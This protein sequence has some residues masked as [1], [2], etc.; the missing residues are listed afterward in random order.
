MFSVVFKLNKKVLSVVLLLF[1]LVSL[2]LVDC[3]GVFG[4]TQKPESYGTD[5]SARVMYIKEFGWLIDEQPVEVQNITIPYKF[6]DVYKQY[7]S[8]Q[9]SQGFNL[10]NYAGLSA[11]RYSYNV[12][13]EEFKGQHVRINLL[14]HD[15]SIIGG[16][17]CSLELNGD[18]KP[19]K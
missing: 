2:T 9:L 8:I 7:N 14:V 19:F 5:N 11:V 13:N 6:N 18:I 1:V 3:F 17:I 12:K 16:D 4:V 15:N 10:E